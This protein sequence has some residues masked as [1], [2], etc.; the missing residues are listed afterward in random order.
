M[1]TRLVEV[2][3]IGLEDTGELLL[4]EDE[5]M[6]EAL[7]PRAPQEPFAESVGAWGVERR[8]QHLDV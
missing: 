5:Q 4:G 3:H 2:G 6:V 1:G 7:T 8:L